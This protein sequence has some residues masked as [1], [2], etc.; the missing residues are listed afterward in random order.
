MMTI[1]D[2]EGQSWR[3]IDVDTLSSIVST[4]IRDL[5]AMILL[6]RVEINKQQPHALYLTYDT[7]I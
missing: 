5:D 3:F 7:G 1:G 4:S 6:D 2:R